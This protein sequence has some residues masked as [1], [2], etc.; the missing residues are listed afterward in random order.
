MFFG[1]AQGFAKLRWQLHIVCVWLCFGHV[2][3]IPMKG[4]PFRS[5][6]AALGLLACL[7]L[8][9]PLLGA[10]RGYWGDV[11]LGYVYLFVLWFALIAL[12]AL[13]AEWLR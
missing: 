10:V 13:F 3:N 5:R 7:L 1:K 2:A 12:M 9:F 6:L 11:P 8:N 4:R